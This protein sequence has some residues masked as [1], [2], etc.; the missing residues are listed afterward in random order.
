MTEWWKQSSDEATRALDLGVFVR[1]SAHEFANPLNAIAMHAELAKSLFNRNEQA[2]AIEAIERLLSSC[3]LC[4]RLL[5]GFRRF[6]AGL[7]PHPGERASVRDIVNSAVELAS[8]E[9]QP[10]PPVEVEEVDLWTFGDKRALGRALAELL[11]N[12]AE[13]DARI[14]RI[15]IRREGASIVVDVIDDG[16]GVAADLRDKITQPFFS[17]R[18]HEGKAG[19]GL[20]LVQEVLSSNGGALQIDKPL[21]EKNSGMCVSLRLSPCEARPT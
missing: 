8:A 9:R 3:A 18:R 1:G 13:A 21:A 17:T 4:G 7:D 20:S 5:Q 11:F 12:A 6:G 2:R 10:F 19:L 14:I 15:S 16:T